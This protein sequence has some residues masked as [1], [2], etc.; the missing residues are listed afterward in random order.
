M[1]EFRDH[2]DDLQALGAEVAAIS[3]DEAGNSEPLRQLYRL[4]FPIL[5]DTRH[6]AIEAWGLYDRAEKGGISRS[7]AFVIDPKRCVRLAS[8][9]GVTSRIRAKGIV[10]FLRNSSTGQPCQP[11]GR[12]VIVPTV[13]EVIRSVV[14]ALK[15]TLSPPKRGS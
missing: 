8:L 4:P 5:C 7:A 12:S 1:A 9:D 15:V 10:N 2:Y 13:G 14:P 6:E 11:P 3:V